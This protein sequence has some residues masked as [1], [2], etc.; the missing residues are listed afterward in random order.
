MKSRILA[1]AICILSLSITACGGGGFS[2]NDYASR[3][4]SA[5]PDYY[6][7]PKDISDPVVVTIPAKFLYRALT[8]AIPED[9]NNRNGLGAVVSAANA[10]PIPFAEFHVYDSGGN[11]VQQ[12]ETN[13]NGLAIFEMPKTTGTYTLKVFSRAYNDYLKVSILEDIYANTPYSISKTFTIGSSNVTSGTLDLTSSPVYA[14]A[15]EA[16]SSKIEGG[17]FNIMYDILLANEYIRR[18]INKNGTV[19]GQPETN[20]NK[21]W[22]AEKV[23]VYWKAGFNP[24][25]YFNSSSP[26][27]FY[28]PG[29]RKLY[30]LGGVNGDVKGSDTDHF[31]D[32]VILHEYGHFLEDVYGNSESP[33]GSHNGNFIIDARLAWSE[34]WA[35]FL[36]GAIL[37]GAEAYSEARQQSPPVT[38]VENRLP[39]SKKF[40]YYVDT[41]GY[42]GG[43][44][45]CIGISFNLAAVGTDSSQPDN[46]DD[47]LPGTGTFREVSIARTLYKSTRSTSSNYDAS[48]PGGGITFANIWKVFSGEDTV[49]HNRA[50]PLSLSLANTAKYPVPNAGLFNWLLD[51]SNFDTT[52]WNDILNEEKQNKT[53]HDYAYFLSSGTCS[54]V[55]F[56]GGT[57]EVKMGTSDSVR[58]SNQQKN[59]D[60]YLYKHDGG[61]ATLTIDISTSGSYPP[62]LDLILYYGSYVYFEDDY[63]YANYKSPY[64]AK[65]S[66]TVASS[67]E[68]ISLS[69]LP[70]GYYMLNV[71]INAY[72]KPNWQMVGM[73]TYTIRKGSQQL[74]GTEQ[75]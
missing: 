32:S 65:Q 44:S 9:I 75:P 43:C 12:G 6:G 18:N 54:G 4:A 62:D 35:N 51:Q 3:P 59:N 47:D 58:R 15:N 1:A 24:Y 26:L 14:E 19:A 37:T 60:F 57:T 27:S 68:T 22:V 63:W 17:A 10:F 45:T 50:N 61:S 74:C 40:N 5:E 23:T 2:P 11:R 36:Q 39:A 8:F 71:K 42:K 16:I 34:G 72:E 56:N 66:R 52:Q 33:G 25:S 38:P 20:T 28:S 7:S 21:W 67:S 70:A 49:G 73:S 31:D 41:Y 13:T 64:I 69:G 29:E 55:T 46:V 53:T 30:I 48:K